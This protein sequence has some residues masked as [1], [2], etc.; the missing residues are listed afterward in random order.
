MGTWVLQQG[1]TT[2]TA[3]SRGREGKKYRKKSGGKL[4]Y[5]H[6]LY[7]FPDYFCFLLIVLVYSIKSF[8]QLSLTFI[9]YSLRK[10]Q[11]FNFC[12]PKIKAPTTAA[13]G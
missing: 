1:V 2:T 10:L 9:S 12:R 8:L 6:H 13:D 11:G 5:T 4:Y 7:F 3:K